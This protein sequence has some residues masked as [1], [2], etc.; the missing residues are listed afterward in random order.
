MN[1]RIVPSELIHI[2]KTQPVLAGDT[3]SGGSNV[4]D[5]LHFGYIDCTNNGYVTTEKGNLY[6]QKLIE[7]LDKNICK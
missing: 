6:V 5:L 4:K 3:L 7:F 2:W 1:R